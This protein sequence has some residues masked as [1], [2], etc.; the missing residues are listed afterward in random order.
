MGERRHPHNGALPKD[1]AGAFHPDGD[2][3]PAGT[4]R[5]DCPGA[6]FP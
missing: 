2:A 1:N 3:R 4:G 6:L 5:P